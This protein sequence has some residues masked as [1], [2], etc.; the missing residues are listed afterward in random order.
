MSRHSVMTTIWA[1]DGTSQLVFWNS[2]SAS[3]ASCV[4]TL[5][6]NDGRRPAKQGFFSASALESPSPV[7]LFPVQLSVCPPWQ[8]GKEGQGRCEI[9]EACSGRST[10]L[11]AALRHQIDGF[12]IQVI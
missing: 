7:Q 1:W 3:T 11:V 2:F 4:L 10:R 6:G 8:K 9:L 12:I 5:C